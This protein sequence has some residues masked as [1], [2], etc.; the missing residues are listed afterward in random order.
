MTEMT[1]V[2]E[3]IVHLIESDHLARLAELLVSETDTFMQ[4]YFSA[5]LAKSTRDPRGAAFLAGHC[6]DVSF[7]FERMQSSDAD[8][9]R[10]NIEILF[11][12]MQDPV[13]SRTISKSEVRHDFAMLARIS[14]EIVK[15]LARSSFFFFF[16]FFK[17][18]F[19]E[20]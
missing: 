8:V 11:N 3:M 17:F 5:I 13:G 4:E 16:F 14:R 19:L 12:L 1:V 15:A 6:S 7:L 18:L 9:K 10:N 2:P 20:I